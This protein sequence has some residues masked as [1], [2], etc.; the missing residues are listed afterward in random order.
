MISDLSCYL[1]GIPAVSEMMQQQKTGYKSI[2]YDQPVT[3]DRVIRNS[4]LIN[5]VHKNSFQAYR[6][7]IFILNDT[8]G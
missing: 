7:Y 3:I 2:S 5:I 6:N 4:Q 1:V 8:M